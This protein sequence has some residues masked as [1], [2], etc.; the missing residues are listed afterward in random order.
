MKEQEGPMIIYGQIE[1][2]KRKGA[3]IRD[4]Y[5]TGEA[6]GLLRFEIVIPIMELRRVV[7]AFPDCYKGFPAPIPAPIVL[8]IGED[9]YFGKLQVPKSRKKDFYSNY[10]VQEQWLEAWI[11]ATLTDL[12]HQDVKLAY[13]LNLGG[14]ETEQKVKGA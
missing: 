5:K 13:A 3:N 12:N 10:D 7:K 8:E 6:E 11:S 14:F 9:A 4:V 2:P 1:D